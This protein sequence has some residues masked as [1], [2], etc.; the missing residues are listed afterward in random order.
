M[1]KIFKLASLI[2]IISLSI[3]GCKKDSDDDILVD[4]GKTRV[5]QYEGAMAYSTWR[6]AG[7]VFDG[8]M[9]NTGGAIQ[10]N[11]SRVSFSSDGISWTEVNAM[12]SLERAWHT[13]VTFNNKLWIIGGFSFVG[14][15]FI[16]G[17]NDVRSTIDGINW[18][19]ET[20]SA[21]FSPRG[22]HSSVVFNNEMYVIGGNSDWGGP[23]SHRTGSVYSSTNGVNWSSRGSIPARDEHASAVY[24]NKI[25]VIGGKSGGTLSGEER[26]DV[27]YSE[28][29]S[30]WVLATDSANFAP[31]YG[32]KAFSHKGKLWVY[33]GFNNQ[34]FRDLWYTEGRCELV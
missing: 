21:S 10:V 4:D 25:W 20:P 11:E 23:T 3:S 9:W 8:K 32:H 5:T 1:Q 31:R 29:G 13:A 17:I 33:G 24:D 30:T 22:G 7:A 27:Y 19:L 2:I 14:T 28:D 12:D 18:V 26:N 6:H 34:Y 15:G 16:E